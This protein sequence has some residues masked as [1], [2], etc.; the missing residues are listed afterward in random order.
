M[1]ARCYGAPDHGIFWPE[2]FRERVL[3]CGNEASLVH[4]WSVAGAYASGGTAT[5]TSFVQPQSWQGC[6]GQ[7]RDL[8]V[9]FGKGF[10]QCRWVL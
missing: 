3:Q 10:V 1:A 5:N 2:M 8:P 7:Q 9:R 4:E 6:R